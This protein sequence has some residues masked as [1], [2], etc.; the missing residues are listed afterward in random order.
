[1]ALVVLLVK[2]FMTNGS[3]NNGTFLSSWRA[4]VPKCHWMSSMNCNSLAVILLKNP[5]WEY[6]QLHNQEV[7]DDEILTLPESSVGVSS[8]VN[9][10]NSDK[11]Q[12][13][14]I[15]AKIAVSSDNSMN[16]NISV[17][18]ENELTKKG[19]I[20][21]RKRY[22]LSAKGRKKQKSAA[23]AQLHGVLKESC[24]ENCKKGCKKVISEQQ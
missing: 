1:M 14:T 9:E 23:P 3:R 18:N 21:K 6:P 4:T 2:R 17:T 22:A 13:A 15:T 20:R 24:K 7:S 12:C 5:V 16:N 11:N 19:T 10:S 8:T